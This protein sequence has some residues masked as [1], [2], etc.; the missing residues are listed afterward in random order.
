MPK[1]LAAEPSLNGSRVDETVLM[2]RTVARRLLLTYRRKHVVVHA[3]HH[4]HKHDRV[5]EKV[6]FNTRNYQ[7]QNAYRDRLA[8]K[9]VMHCRLRDQQQVFKVMPE[10]NN[11]RSS[12]PL[13]GSSGEAFS[14]HPDADQHHQRITVMQNFRLNEPRIP[15]T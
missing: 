10:L 4:W 12:P 15:Q 14:Q 7:L 3:D 9:I 13:A 6:E 1:R 2:Q 8:P 11:Q 5:I